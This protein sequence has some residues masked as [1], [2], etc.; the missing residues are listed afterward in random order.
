MKA[1]LTGNCYLC[2]ASLGK[3]AMKNHFL[4]L[5]EDSNGGQECLLLKIEGAYNKGYWLYIDIPVD[6]T[7]SDVDAFLRR[8]WLECCGHMSMFCRSGYN[9]KIDSG[10]KLKKFP[11][12][13]KFFHYYDFG[14]TTETLITVMG[15][16]M[17]K[18]QKDAVRLLARNT[19]PVSECKDCGKTAEF[20]YMEPDGNY[21]FP[22]YCGKCS[23]KHDE[24]MMNPITN[25]PRMGECGYTGD[26]DIF[27]FDPASMS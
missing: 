5:H 9:D 26:R 4:K 6:K 24:L 13:D 22:F 2:G 18:Q 17:R 3:V 25:S 20:I 23:R 1:K 15:N 8:I 19:P 16:I 11:V 12:G 7:L 21:I 14:S 10:S 27:T